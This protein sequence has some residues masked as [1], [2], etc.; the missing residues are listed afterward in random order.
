MTGVTDARPAVFLDRDGVLNVDV[1]YL[2]RVEDLVWVDGA[3]DAVRRLSHAGFQVFVVTNQSGIAR[4]YYDGA[5][6]ERLHAH[7][8]ELIQ[9]DGGRIDD[10]ATAPSILITVGLLGITWS[11]GGSRR[12]HA[13]RPHGGLAIRRECSFLIGD[14]QSDIEAAEAAGV[15]GYLF[16]G[17][18]LAA[19]LETV[20][21]SHPP[22]SHRAALEVHD[23]LPSLPTNDR[24]RPR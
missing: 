12:G 10:F 23:G 16:G 8:A 2:H 1:G 19:F 17:G 21:E 18:D 6:V 22:L 24:M 11:T 15:P 14:K 7:M 13:A 9:A 4:G 5:A 20:P 3:R